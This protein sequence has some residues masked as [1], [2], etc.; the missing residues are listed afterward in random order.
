MACFLAKPHLKYRLEYLGPQRVS[1]AEHS[2][3]IS[4]YFERF[5]EFQMYRHGSTQWIF[6]DYGFLSPG[7]LHV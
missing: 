4:T 6:E 1:T 3:V 5:N 2:S 7:S